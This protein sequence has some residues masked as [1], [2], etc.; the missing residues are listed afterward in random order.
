MTH[1]PLGMPTLL[2]MPDLLDCAGFCAQHG[3]QF[4]E[5]NMNLPQYQPDTI[6]TSAILAAR[7]IHGI[8]CTLHLDENMNPWDFNPYVRDAYGQTMRAAVSLAKTYGMPIINIHFHSGVYFTLSKGRTYLYQQHAA[9]F[10]AGLR[11]FRL[12]CED[13]IGGSA[14]SV[15]IEN[16]DGFEPFALDGIAYLLESDVFALTLDIGHAQCAGNSDLAFFAA[17][18]NRLQHVHIH[19]ATAKTCHLPLGE[20]TLDI[21]KAF[22]LAER[23][24]CR[25]VIEVKTIAGLTASLQQLR[26]FL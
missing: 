24:N 11:Q 3:L 8:G 19:D 23:R 9:A 10:Q 26:C 17:H 22:A 25:A 21:G 18:E 13:G 4:V 15:C 2:E 1:V 5:L 6:D 16:T 20:G 7:D 12:L 14:V